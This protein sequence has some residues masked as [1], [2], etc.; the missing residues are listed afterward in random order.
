[1]ANDSRA[2]S[3]S[4][5]RNHERPGLL[6]GPLTT[7]DNHT[8]DA[9][10]FH[11]TTRPNRLRQGQGPRQG[12]VGR[13]HAGRAGHRR[14]T[15]S[16]RSG[17]APRRAQGKPLRNAQGEPLRQRSGRAA[18]RGPGAPQP[19]RPL[20]GTLS[21]RHDWCSAAASTHISVCA[22]DGSG[23]PS[24]VHGALPRASGV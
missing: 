15:R 6:P 1:M 23:S 5:R 24:P 2:R 10:N 17:Q 11:A 7:R 13:G 22:T 3:L 21:L 18:D 14:T 9:S 4:Y 12:Q 20:P 8:S 16:A 19:S